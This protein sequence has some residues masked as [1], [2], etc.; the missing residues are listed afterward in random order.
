LSAV[1]INQQLCRLTKDAFGLP[2]S[3]HLFRD[4]AATS[5]AVHAPELIGI[6]HLIL[7]NTYAVMEKHYNLARVIDA[8]RHFYGAL[9]LE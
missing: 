8:G 7:G 9:G 3:P 6:A 4:C 1:S 5:L 2:I